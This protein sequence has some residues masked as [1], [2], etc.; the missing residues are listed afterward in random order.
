MNTFADANVGRND[1]AALRQTVRVDADCFEAGAVSCPQNNFA[2][3][4]YALATYST[5]V[6]IE[7]FHKISP[8]SVFR[9]L[10]R[11]GRAGLQA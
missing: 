5:E 6:N 8:L 1:A 10:N 2:D 9:A 11:F 3:Q 4:A 7:W